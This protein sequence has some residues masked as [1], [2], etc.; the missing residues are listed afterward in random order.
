MKEYVIPTIF[1][2]LIEQ[3]VSVL[4]SSQPEPPEE[5]VITIDPHVDPDG[6]YGDAKGNGSTWGFDDE[7]DD[8]DS[9]GH[10]Y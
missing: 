1:V 2:E 10:G 6:F 3:D 4:S 9:I 8:Y 5:E 7:E